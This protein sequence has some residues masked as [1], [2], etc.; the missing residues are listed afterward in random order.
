MI[1]VGIIGVGYWGPNLVRN[2]YNNPLCNLKTVCDVNSKRL[3][4]I[5][6][7]YPDIKITMESDSVILDRNIDA[8]VIATP[9]NTHYDLAYRALREGKHVFVEKPL[10]DNY[11]T[12]LKLNEMAHGKDKILV[13][14]HIFQFA[15]AV[16]A[17]KEKVHSGLIGDIH[18]FSSQRINLGP[19]RTRVS[20]LWDLGPHDLSILLYLLEE[21][22]REIHAFGNSYWWGGIIDNVHLFLGFESGKSAHIHVSWLSANKTRVINIM[23]EKGNLIYDDTKPPTEKVIFFDKGTDNRFEINKSAEEDLQYGIGRVENVEVEEG[24]PLALEV[25]AFLNAVLN[26]RKPINNGD[27]GVEVVR[28]LELASKQI[29][30]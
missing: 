9:V 2:F 7:K 11:D 15:P 1:N 20:V 25:D 13:V 10:T 14:G 8:I 16:K 24:E 6:R 29:R 18:H 19:P 17:I 27:I 12:A 5:H 3:D 4:Y 30:S 23:G 21:F 28:I 22:P 26:G